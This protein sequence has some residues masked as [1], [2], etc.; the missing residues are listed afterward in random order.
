M[1]ARA[2]Q[3][4]RLAAGELGMASAAWLY[5]TTTHADQGDAGVS[6]LRDELGRAWPVL[7]AVCAGW[8]DGVRPGLPDTAGVLAR[9]QGA[10][11]LLLIG[12]ETRWIDALVAALPAAV[13]VGLVRVSPLDPDWPRVVAN[14][15]GRVELVDLDDF[16]AWAGPR[17]VLLT[18]GYG[19]AGQQLFVLPSWLRVAGPDVRLQFRALVVWQ[20]LDLPLEVYPRWLVEAGPDSLTDLIVARP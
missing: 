12:I 2:D 5:A 8:L 20:V 10:T 13:H 18:W 15:G 14:H 1:T 6:R 16:Q 3:A 7:D 17:S 9:L 19:R 11:R 4:F